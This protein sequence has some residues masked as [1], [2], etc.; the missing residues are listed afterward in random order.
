MV[1]VEESPSLEEQLSIVKH[2]T[3]LIDL[4]NKEGLP[5]EEEQGVQ[6]EFVRAIGSSTIRTMLLTNI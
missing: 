6:Q 2:L 1:Y 3:K 4:S 5:K